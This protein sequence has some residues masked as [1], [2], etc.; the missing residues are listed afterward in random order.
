MRYA[1]LDVFYSMCVVS[2]KMYFIVLPYDAVCS[3]FRLDGRVYI[4]QRSTKCFSEYF[5]GEGQASFK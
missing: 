5:S 3:R 4:T 2:L 1:L